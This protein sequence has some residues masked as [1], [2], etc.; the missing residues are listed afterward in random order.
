LLEEN[1]GDVIL[2]PGEYLIAL[3][4]VKHCRFAEPVCEVVF[5]ERST[6]LD[7]RNAGQP[8]RCRQFA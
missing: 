1:G 2:S 7:A 4:G 5:L 6:T 3:H 8:A